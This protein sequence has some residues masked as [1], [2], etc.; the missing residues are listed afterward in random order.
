MIIQ[1][2]MIIQVAMI[3]QDG[4]IIQVAMIIQEGMIIQY[5][6]DNSGLQR[7]FMRQ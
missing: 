1:E 7:L 2:R 6:N 4:M 3:I 5:S